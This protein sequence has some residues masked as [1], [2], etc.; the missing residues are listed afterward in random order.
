M[1]PGAKVSLF[2]E[3]KLVRTF[4]KL[5]MSNIS[6]TFVLNLFKVFY[7]FDNLLNKIVKKTHT[8]L[9]HKKYNLEII[10]DFS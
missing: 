3:M 6:I 8:M 7:C 5:S 10:P 4:G 1:S 9:K 2:T